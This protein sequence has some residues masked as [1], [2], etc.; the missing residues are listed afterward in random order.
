[1]EELDMG[2]QAATIINADKMFP[3]VD[4]TN[5]ADALRVVHDAFSMVATGQFTVAQGAK[6]VD[7]MWTK[8]AEVGTDASGRISDG[9]KELIQLNEQYGTQSKEI[10]KFLGEQ[11]TAA[12]NAF[13]AIS[14]GSTDVFD[15]VKDQQKVWMDL[16]KEMD[17]MK[18][19]HDKA[20]ES[21]KL[22]AEQEKI[23]Q[24]ELAAKYVEMNGLLAEKQLLAE[25]AGGE[26]ENLGMIAVATYGAAVAAGKTHLEALQLVAPG[27]KDL[28]FAYEQLGLGIED[29]GLKSLM[30]ASTILE[31]N[32]YLIE[33]IGGLSG[34]MIA[35]DNIGQLNADTFTRMQTQGMTMYTK[36]QAAV[37][38]HGGAAQDALMPMQEYL[39]AAEEQAIKLGVPLDANTQML[40]DQSK[41]LGVWKEKGK[42]AN[43]QLLEGINK[44]NDTMSALVANVNGVGSGLRNIPGKVSSDVVIT[45]YNRTG[46]VDEEGNPIPMAEGGFGT[47]NKPT[48][49]MTSED[50]RP[51]QFAFS[52][53]GKQFDKATAAPGGGEGGVMGDPASLSFLE[54]MDRTLRDLPRAMSIAMKDAAVQA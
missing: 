50:G 1:M 21:G 12:G 29:A 31:E 2:Q 28:T 19:K 9:M 52:G 48:L 3:K 44:L 10:A 51:E 6:V 36:L 7:D 15:K 37:V 43:E 26:L 35:L 25:A 14:K 34:S 17:S 11:A 40:I 41:E 5:F 54:S 13:T 46:E 24:G 42:T 32:P 18:E 38:E 39:H 16:G 4:A 30:M 33:A 20:A 45:T 22:T 53:Q 8:L 23:Y 47:T 49:F 27:M